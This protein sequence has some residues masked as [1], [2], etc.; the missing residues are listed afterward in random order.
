MTVC[1]SRPG[2]EAARAQG[3]EGPGGVPGGWG[4]QR[5][6]VPC[7]QD[8]C[9]HVDKPVPLQMRQHS[10][11]PDVWDILKWD[12]PRRHGEQGEPLSGPGLSGGCR[13]LCSA[14]AV[15][16]VL[17][18]RFGPRGGL[19]DGGPTPA[20]ANTLLDS[21]RLCPQTQAPTGPTPCLGREL[22]AF[23]K[24]RGGQLCL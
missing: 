1:E 17:S 5:F 7:L 10:Q 20:G 11:I 21:N 15:R 8:R 18:P 13:T 14:S 19:R 2:P 4:G 12:S 22:Q 24:N 3:G 9:G 6:S 16:G 23:Q